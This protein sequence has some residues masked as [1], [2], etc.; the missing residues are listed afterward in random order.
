MRNAAHSTTPPPRRL[1]SPRRSAATPRPR[2]PG[3]R[4]RDAVG[5]L[6]VEQLTC[7][8]QLDRAPR[9]A[10]AAAAATSARSATSAATSSRHDD[11]PAPPASP[12]SSPAASARARPTAVSPT[13]APTDMP[14][15]AAASPTTAASSGLNRTHT[16]S[17]RAASAR[18]RRRDPDT[19]HRT[20][21]RCSSRPRAS[22]TSVPPPFPAAPCPAGAV[23]ATQA[24]HRPP[25]GSSSNDTTCTRRPHTAI[26]PS[27]S[28]GSSHTDTAWNSRS[29]PS[30][31]HTHGDGSPADTTYHPDHDCPP[32]V[33]RP[34]SKRSR[35][36]G[37]VGPRTGICGQHARE[38]RRCGQPCGTPRF[39]TTLDSGKSYFPHILLRR[40]HSR[41][42]LT[43]AGNPTPS[44]PPLESWG[45]T[46]STTATTTDRPRHFR[47]E[48]SPHTPDR[49]MR[50]RTDPHPPLDRRGDQGRRLHTGRQWSDPERRPS[51]VRPDEAHRDRR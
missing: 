47:D 20:S 33:R 23:A 40:G 50:V 32:L 46:R 49:A 1:R 45:T 48:V 38:T 7:R 12:G 3:P 37:P 22:P 13:H 4:R 21:G 39:R 16:D 9:P 6:V 43:R 30:R 11:G 26:G 31:S 42:Q 18:A 34:S 8:A 10:R 15:R 24:G 29:T 2:R 28:G 51:P 35:N 25:S 19:P 17:L 27:S 5:G 14:A 41:E 36:D 44:G